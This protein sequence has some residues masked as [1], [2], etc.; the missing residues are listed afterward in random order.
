MTVT[1]L[2]VRHH[3]PGSARA[4]RDALVALGPDL[5]LIEG[6]P[7]ADALVPLAADPAMRPP[8]ALLA[9]SPD[10]PQLSAYW[11]F[12]VFSPEWQALRYALDAGVPARFC[13]LPAAHQF[14]IERTDNPS[15]EALRTDPI[16]LLASAA[17]YDDAE[18]WW[19]DVVEHRRD[20]TPPFA[21][22][23][24]A[25]TELRGIGGDARLDSR[26]A[27]R[28][29]YMRTVLRRSMRAGHENI[30]VVCGAWHV[31]ALA[32]LP[33]A[34]ADAQ[35]LKG[36]PKTKVAAT[37]V[38]WTH[39]RLADS[40]G[41]GAGVASPGWY[42]HLFSA[43][44]RVVERW[45]VQAAA[46]LRDE[47][48]PASSAH[49]IEA[50]RLAE[51]LAVVRG[52]PHAGLAEVDDA[53]RSVLCE[54]SDTAAELIR[55]R[56]EI[57]EAL[58]QVPAETPM[59][60]LQ[61]DLAAEQRRLRLRASAL[62]RELGL[63]LRKPMDVDRSRLLHRLQLLEIEWGTVADGTRGKGTFHED[64]KLAWQPEY[65]VAV[66]S[67][68]RWGT[69]VLDAAT[70]R[71]RSLAAEA[72]ALPALTRL[73]EQCLLADLPDAFP[74]VIAQLASRAARDTDVVQLMAALPPLTRTV[75]YGDVRGT[76]ITSVQ[77]VA[78]QLLLRIC[79]GLP[80]AASQRDDDGARELVRH[81]DA[82][83]DAVRLLE[84]RDGLADQWIGTVRTL[85]DRDD[86]HGLI[87]G[88]CL[89]LL[90]D[91]GT[92]VDVAVHMERALS[93]GTTPARAAAWIEGFL[94]DSGLPLVH[95]DALFALVDAWIAG[96]P[97][98]S[99]AELLPLLR[100]T[101]STFSTPERNTIGARARSQDR[102][103][104]PSG[105]DDLD[106]ER[107]ERVVP[108]VALLLGLEMSTP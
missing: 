8:V 38:P 26:T 37:W 81:I 11:P 19:D 45:M 82:V 61:R 98:G 44:D 13:D 76:D 25:M 21:A 12:A 4:V 28:E 67:A 50:V 43:P 84:P 103:R 71:A 5:V 99:F 20:G 66:I 57:G 58:G 48:Q 89:R 51:T 91:H 83:H 55:R 30:A 92:A 10:N 105:P 2:G 1:L 63:D 24:E 35:I 88:R 9:Y 16:G 107:A 39:G 22:I 7:E 72:V 75:R 68:S 79:V 78:E 87:N 41:Y 49:A 59:V 73:I 96:I 14:A 85:A 62:V 74:G 70:S 101:F 93:I 18:R 15:A 90:R 64:W 3:G 102:G 31:P 104:T 34:S 94:A 6:P 42:H 17:G 86:L 54:G 36:L 95:D 108:T 23:A 69:T 100:R 32:T 106:H 56:L 97:G 53:I 60:A 40:S 46:V 65:A 80:A 52:R 33:A 77:E 27:Q 47:G 29:A